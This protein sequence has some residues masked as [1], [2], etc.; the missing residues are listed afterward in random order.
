MYAL[1][2]TILFLLSFTM[3]HPL[4]VDAQNSDWDMQPFIDIQSKRTMVPV[5][6][7]SEDL[8]AKV[9]WDPKA[10]QVKLELGEDTVLLTIGDSRAYTNGKM[11]PLDTVPI[12]RNGR[13]FV[14]LRFISETFGANVMWVGEESKVLVTTEEKT[15][16]MKINQWENTIGAKVLGQVD[17]HSVELETNTGVAVYQ[18]SADV[19]KQ[20]PSW[21]EESFVLF[22]SFTDE[23][24]SQ[25]ITEI[26]AV[27]S[28]ESPAEQNERFAKVHVT[29][30]N[31]VYWVLGLARVF[32]GQLGYVVE[33]GHFE[34]TRGFESAS[35][36]APEWGLFAFPIN[37]NQLDLDMNTSLTLILYE[38]SPKDGSRQYE[39]PVP[40][41]K[42]PS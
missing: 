31:N 19:M 18:L 7:I 13:T 14:P 20:I 25:M 8:G 34:L 11:Q 39:L 35:K 30:S 42:P 1:R 26:L 22:K 23:L 21:T 28:T 2:V 29:H 41:A 32:E 37:I 10:R 5:R 40:L 24:G 17:P 27:H 6:F 12:I 3:L 4:P 16:E 36:G 9:S 38:E 33:D 15:I